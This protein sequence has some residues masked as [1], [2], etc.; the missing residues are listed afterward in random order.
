MKN[1]L[2]ISLFTV[3]FSAISQSD[4]L[5][6]KEYFMAPA[7][8]KFKEK[9]PFQAPEFTEELVKEALKR[10]MKACSSCFHC[11]DCD[12]EDE[13][14]FGFSFKE[15]RTVKGFE[16]EYYDD[17]VESY[18]ERGFY[19][20][21]QFRLYHK[22]NL[23]EADIKKKADQEEV[24]KKL[25]AQTKDLGKRLAELFAKYDHSQVV[26]R[27]WKEFAKVMYVRSPDSEEK[28]AMA[29][30][31]KEHAYEHMNDLD[32]TLIMHS[33][34]DEP[35]DAEERGRI[36]KML[37][38]SGYVEFGKGEMD[39][40]GFTPHYVVLKDVGVYGKPSSS[41]PKIPILARLKELK[42][43]T[44]TGNELGRTDWF[45]DEMR[46]VF[47]FWYEDMASDFARE[48]FLNCW[49]E[50]V[51]TID[52]VL[53]DEDALEDLIDGYENFMNNYRQH[54]MRSKNVEGKNI[55]PKETLF[56][57]LINNHYKLTDEKYEELKKG[58]SAEI[59]AERDKKGGCLRRS[60]RF[61]KL[62]DSG[63]LEYIE[64]YMDLTMTRNIADRSFYD[65][66]YEIK[67]GNIYTVTLT[68][69][70]TGIKLPAFEMKINST[71]SAVYLGNDK[72]PYKNEPENA[73]LDNLDSRTTWYSSDGNESFSTGS[74]LGTEWNSSITGGISAEGYIVTLSNTK[75]L[76]KVT[77]TSWGGDLEDPFIPITTDAACKVLYYGKGKKKFV[78][79]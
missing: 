9:N 61:Y 20:F 79:R 62:N 26:Y 67:S 3:T 7:L 23:K 19:S 44:H 45:Y 52:Q 68:D 34:S 64:F 73:C 30:F 43:L 54:R 51:P 37:L 22:T 46:Y 76:F 17:L 36:R 49:G 53:E 60:S 6:I 12:T 50:K 4:D 55:Y 56:K 65:G 58:Y 38:D 69:R 35:I 48:N 25:H 31:L 41:K 42:K 40:D 1:L 14:T 29:A 75:Y 66:T 18:V 59:N 77:K 8:E 57:N 78:R 21:D 72:V 16:F 5:L 32:R 27:K 47:N 15:Y 10:A 13:E 74:V 71:C 63:D 11:R 70:K 28:E 33:P 2:I 39:S 24:L